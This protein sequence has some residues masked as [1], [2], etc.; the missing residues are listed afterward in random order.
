MK[1]PL[2]ALIVCFHLCV[3][4]VSAW[5]KEGK[6]SLSSILLDALKY[7]DVVNKTTK[8]YLHKIQ[9]TRSFVFTTRSALVKVPTLP[10]IPSSVSSPQL[11]MTR[12]L[13]PTVNYP[14]KSTRTK[15]EQL[16]S[17]TMQ[18]QLPRTRTRKSPA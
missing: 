15:H 17:Q 5:S 14:S 18:Q 12:L 7:T 10:S 13:N 11:P 6:F 3:V 4:F 2:Q 16:S 1:L 8:L 9:T